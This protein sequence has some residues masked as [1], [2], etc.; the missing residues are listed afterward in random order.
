MR[1][2]VFLDTEASFLARDY[3]REGETKEQALAR[4]EENAKRALLKDPVCVIDPVQDH[5]GKPAQL[6]VIDSISQEMEGYAGL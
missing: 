5:P 3:L 4:M 6:F 1:P 2:K